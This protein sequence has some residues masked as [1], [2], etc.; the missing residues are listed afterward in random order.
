MG[1]NGVAR[2]AM[3]GKEMAT[4][5]LEG[6]DGQFSLCMEQQWGLESSS[7]QENG[8]LARDLLLHFLTL[9]NLYASFITVNFPSGP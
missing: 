6:D 5:P 3:I 9:S 1:R 7:C 4:E 8:I 2:H